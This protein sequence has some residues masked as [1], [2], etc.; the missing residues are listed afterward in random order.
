MASQLMKELMALIDEVQDKYDDF[1]GG[2]EVI[3]KKQDD[4]DIQKVIDFIK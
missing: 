4:E 3:M 1:V 2:M